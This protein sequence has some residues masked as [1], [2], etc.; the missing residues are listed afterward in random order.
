[1][2]ELPEVE[3]VRIGL[4]PA[5]I[6]RRVTAIVPGDFPGVMGESGIELAAAR[7]IDRPIARIDRRG[8][9]LILV[10]FDGDGVIIH[11][12]MTGVLT[13][14]DAEQ[15]LPRFHRL[16]LQLD[17]PR[18][19]R[20]ADQRKFGRVLAATDRDIDA[21]D[22]KLGT[23]PLDDQFTPEVLAAALRGRTAPVKA[24][25]LDQTIVAGLGNIY[26]DEALFKAGIHP[27]TP[28]G[29]LDPEQIASLRT[30]IRLVLADGVRFR[31]TS[32]SSFRNAYGDSGENQ[33]HLSVYG[34]AARGE[35]CL[36]CGAPLSRIVVGGRGTHFCPVCQPASPPPEGAN[37]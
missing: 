31:G 2:P 7:I 34:R 24:L 32:F 13:L 16:T 6:G 25:L 9:Y 1:M 29:K 19:L 15:P 35:A 36:V 28:A 21:L 8:K 30:A 11:L 3:T 18:E 5:L 14:E 10:F 23:E 26:V 17:G 12:R 4:E 27:M 22:R 33:H 37:P 20:Y